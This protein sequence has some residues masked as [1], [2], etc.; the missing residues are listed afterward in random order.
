MTLLRFLNFPLGRVSRMAGEVLPKEKAQCGSGPRQSRPLPARPVKVRQ[1]RAA[2]KRAQNV[3]Q[4]DRVNGPGEDVTVGETA[5]IL[6]EVRGGCPAS[7][8]S[9]KADCGGV[10]GAGHLSPALGNR[11]KARPA[12]EYFRARETF[13][14]CRKC[15]RDVPLHAVRCV[16]GEPSP[17]V[18][19]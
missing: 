10:Y 13:H 14:I 5:V 1:V 17:E 6:Q 15:R 2:E 3:D 4:R 11:V 7:F 19:E 12:A 9:G 16:C 18:E 8:G